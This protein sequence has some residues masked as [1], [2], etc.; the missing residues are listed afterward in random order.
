MP[1][2]V[3]LNPYSG[4]WKARERWPEAATALRKAGLEFDMVEMTGINDGILKGEAAARQGFSP[5]IAAGGDGGI[6]EVV[7][8]LYKANPGGTL[9][10]LGVM[11]LGTANDLAV[12]LGLPLD[13]DEAAG[14]IAAGKTRRIDLIQANE[15]VFDN[16][17]AVGLEP[18]VTQYNIR[19][20]KLKGVIRYLAAAVRAIWSE[21]KW[22][23]RLAW[24][25][26]RYEGP[27]SLVTV[28]NCAITGG[29][30]HMAPAAD[31]ADG[32]L[33]FVYGYAPN[34]W[35]M[36][37]LLPRTLNGSYVNDPAIHQHHTTRLEIELSSTSPI[38][39]DGEIRHEALT[40]VI[41]QVVPGKL[42]ILVKA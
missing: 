3:I 19:M 40:K 37:G 12:N 42:D 26:G 38:Q 24:D 21:P 17:S 2:R 7:N 18:V 10:P 5:I 41:Y 32:K 30:F 8:G 1:A 20:V 39:V 35:K 31:P 13:L 15:W 34:R 29:L 16:N 6:S 14:V 33:T 22:T 27:V 25:D 36:F 9:G 23:A 4:R 28:G 11:P